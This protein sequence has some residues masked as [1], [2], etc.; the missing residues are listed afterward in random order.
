MKVLI[1]GGDG[2][3]GSHLAEALQERGYDITL[4]DIKYS[5]NTSFLRCEKIIG[6]VCRYEN[7]SEAAH[8]KDLLIHLAA[9]SRVDLGQQDPSRCLEVNVLGTLNVLK[10]AVKNNSVLILG[11]SR[12]V[13]GEPSIV[14]V[15]EDDPKNPISIYGVSKLT[16][17]NLTVSYHLTHALEY[18]ILRLSNVY[19]S[20]R[21]LPE[22]VIPK[23]MRLAMINEPLRIYGGNQVLD[24]AF[25]D[26]I[27]LG[28]ITLVEKISRGE[29]DVL[30]QCYNIA[31]GKGTSIV[32]LARLIKE[33]TKSESQIIIDKK[34]PFDVTRFVGDISK[35]KK[36][37]NYEPRYSLKE[38]L[39]LLHKRLLAEQT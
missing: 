4:L 11:S 27:I 7:V 20:P 33:V 35:A 25:I 23:F 32:E 9:V 22:R 2:F 15:K 14:P 37:L 6:D 17:E 3:I 13:Y 5:K 39:T 19:G 8:G 21:D 29:K 10:C 12:E 26:D 24:F 1:T 30:N 28:I 18:S 38:G 31:S 36:Y 16:A 34:R